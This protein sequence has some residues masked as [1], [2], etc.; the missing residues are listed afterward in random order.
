MM[1]RTILIANRGEIA[2][3]IVRTC[4]RLGIR[5]IA[6]YA[7]VDRNALHVERADDA[8]RIENYLD[9]A[10]VI[11]AAKTAGAE[12]I[13]PGYGFLSE[14]AALVE[15]CA[16]AGIA[17]VGPTAATLRAMGD[18]D[19][20]K[21]AVARAGVPV[22]PGYH[23]T[24]DPAAFRE[25]AQRIGYPVVIKPVAGGGGKGMHIVT[26]ESAL[27]ETLDVARREARSS[28]GD[29]RLFLEKLIERPRHVEV[30][31]FGDTHGNLVHLYARDCSVQRRHQKVI[32]EAPVD[33]HALFIAAVA[34]ARAVNYV[35]AGTFEFLLAPDGDFYFLEAN[36]RLQ[37]EHPVTEMITALDL[38]EWQLRV[39]AGETLPLRQSDIRAA[40]HAIEA[41]I[42]AEDPARDFMPAP[43]RITFLQFPQNARVDTGVRAGDTIP[44]DYD[45][46]IA[47]LVVHGKDRPEAVARLAHAL[48]QTRIA[49]IATNVEFLAAIARHP[50]FVRSTPE[51]RGSVD[52]GFIARELA[53]LV[54][55]AA[56]ASED[57]LHAAARRVLADRAVATRDAAARSPE[58][59]SPWAGADGW[60]LNDA[61]HREVQLVDGE[62]VVRASGNLSGGAALEVVREGEMLTVFAPG[63]RRDLRLFDPFTAAAAHVLTPTLAAPMPGVIT[64]V[65]VASG[66][67]VAQGA[68][69]VSLEAMKVEH[70]L[71]APA[72][73]TVDAIHCKVG[74]RVSEGA[75]LVVFTARKQEGG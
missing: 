11:G 61:P 5:S 32:E 43:G 64:A 3:R 34:A 36:T 29:D 28:F 38:V 17:F 27:T 66:A 37:V 46:M 24:Q 6:V 69:L 72:A 48:E 31:V 18:K 63:R 23:G 52:T 14:N 20:A 44:F 74:D 16:A 9:I 68:P 51:G 71:R 13:H 39:A 2:C 12:A 75:E 53:A 50:A 47:K 73:G 40:G 42:Y 21:D 56:P 58:P 25:A 49:G 26:Q 41:R 19:A 57:E 65:H 35:N 22:V 62:R 70:T 10:S 67:T 54:P 45:P 59:F 60:Q 55:A 30:Q 1:F 8:L 15:A 7:D 33:H 4:R